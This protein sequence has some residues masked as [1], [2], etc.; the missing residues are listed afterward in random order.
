MGAI[1]SKIQLKSRI[2]S[3]DA[4]K[5]SKKTISTNQTFKFRPVTEEERERLR[6]DVYKYIL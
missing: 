5:H 1:T 2:N 4:T 6:V 3:M